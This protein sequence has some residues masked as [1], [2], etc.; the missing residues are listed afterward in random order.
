M[1][2]IQETCAIGN[3]FFTDIANGIFCIF[4]AE[5]LDKSDFEILAETIFAH[6]VRLQNICDA[7]VPFAI[8]LADGNIAS[9][10]KNSLFVRQS[11]GCESVHFSIP[12]VNL[13]KG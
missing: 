7:Q 3:V 2:A 10:E 1:C 9:V 6:V 11:G 5:L 13:V 12:F 8:V 4:R